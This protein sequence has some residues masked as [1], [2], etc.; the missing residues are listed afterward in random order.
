MPEPLVALRDVTRDNWHTCIGLKVRPEQQS[1]VASNI[2]S[3]AEAKIEPWLV[4]QAV[5][6]GE[7][8]VG[9]VMYGADPDHDQYWLMRLM[10]DERYQGKGYGR[11]AAVAAIERLGAYPD[12]HEVYLGHEPENAV[13]ARLYASLGFERAGMIGDEIM[14]RLRL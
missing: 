10:V 7:E 12:C 5:Y 3:L 11:A 14:L 4:P 2:Y 8:L 13:A 9:F 1:F 6:A